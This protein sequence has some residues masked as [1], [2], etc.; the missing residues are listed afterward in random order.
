MSLSISGQVGIG[1]STPR[2]AL[3]INKTKTYNMGL[4]LPANTNPTNLINPQGGSVAE[5]TI[6]Y[7]STRKCP[8]FYNGT[9][10]SECL[11]D[12]CSGTTTP[13][14]LADCA[15]NGFEGTYL[16]GV[17]LSGT[18]FTVTLTNNSFST[19]TFALQTSDLVLR[20]ISSGIT[21]SSVSPASVTLTAGQTQI[22][23]Y[24]LTGTPVSTGTL[25]ELGANFLY[26]VL[27]LPQF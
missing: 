25:Q 2:G 14:L 5:G 10:W 18:K 4:V 17:A 15:E 20:G 22:V 21:V 16:N 23:T 7:D 6:M 19:A 11:C 24:T 27:I 26:S 1:T 9:V 12:Q 8:R 3:D 13:T